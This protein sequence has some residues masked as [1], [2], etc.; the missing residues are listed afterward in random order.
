MS[1]FLALFACL[2]NH[3]SR[4]PPEDPKTI[5]P[6][7]EGFESPTQPNSADS[8]PLQ[9][10]SQS[11]T[12]PTMN[13]PLRSS[14]LPTSSMSNFEQSPIGTSGTPP[15]TQLPHT[16][17]DDAHFLETLSSP[18]NN[19]SDKTD[20][21]ENQHTDDEA[22]SRR[23]VSVKRFS[24]DQHLLSPTTLPRT[25]ANAEVANVQDNPF[26]RSP[27]G[28]AVTS[29]VSP[30]CKST[31]WSNPENSMEKQLSNLKVGGACMLEYFFVSWHQSMCVFNP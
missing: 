21:F 14:Q 5:P 3:W 8:M 6:K 20:F 16:M 1:Q 7:M 22:N 27:S 26:V 13:S 15:T 29:S 23:D 10:L 2:D 24:S 12:P 18:P 17:F 28:L 11:L 19:I 4:L 9:C 25:P 30:V 31:Q